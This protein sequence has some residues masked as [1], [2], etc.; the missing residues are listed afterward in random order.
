MH[1]SQEASGQSGHDT[2]S[3][4]NSMQGSHLWRFQRR[5]ELQGHHLVSGYLRTLA[6]GTTTYVLLAAVPLLLITS[7]TSIK[8]CHN[9]ENWVAMQAH[10][11]NRSLRLRSVREAHPV[12]QVLFGQTNE[13]PTFFRG[14]TEQSAVYLAVARVERRAEAKEKTTNVGLR[15]K[16]R[17]H[18][19]MWL[20]STI[21]TTYE[22]SSISVDGDCLPVS[23]SLRKATD[24]I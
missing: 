7:S 11:L 8:H 16:R 18:V 1:G 10:N 2:V 20:S 13:R 6:I 4:T 14:D 24:V 19:H 9:F 23:L 17:A 5:L 15:R 21:V 12:Q 22:H 3:R